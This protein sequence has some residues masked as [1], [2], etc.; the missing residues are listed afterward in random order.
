MFSNRTRQ[1]L[2]I[3]VVAD[4]SQPQAL[5]MD[6]GESRPV[7]YRNKLSVRY[8]QSVVGQSVS[9]QPKSAYF[10]TRGPQG[11]EPLRMEQL[12]FGKNTP[13]KSPAARVLPGQSADKTTIAVKLYVDDDEPTHR[14]IWEAK[15]RNRIAAAS[16]ILM[17]HCGVELQVVGVDTWDSDDNQHDFDRSLREFEREADPSPA[18]L[19]I[20]FSSQYQVQTGRHHAGGTRGAL[21]PYI[22][23]KERS[24]KTLE[25]Q[26]L[27]LLLHE[28]GHYLGASHSPEPQSIM[29]P[30][31]TSSIQRRAEAKIQFDPVNTLLMAML[32]DEIR[33]RRVKRL[34][35]VSNPT[36]IR[37][38]EIYSVLAKAMPGD[39][40][41]SQ[42]LSLLGPVAK[43]QEES[44]AGPQ[45]PRKKF[46]VSQTDQ[47]LAAAVRKMNSRLV[48]AVRNRRPEDPL[49][50]PTKWYQKDQ[51]TEFYVRQA[52]LMALQVNPQEPERAF[53][54]T[55]GIFMDDTG[56]LK[57]FPPSV[58]FVVL[59]ESVAQRNLRLKILDKP[60]IM[61]RQ[62]LA[63][64]FFVTAHLAAVHGPETAVNLGLAK[65]V[66]DSK[67]SS[68]FSHVDLLADLAGAEFARHV[69]DGEV[70]LE[71][72]SESFRVSDYMPSIGG[73]KEGQT[74]EEVQAEYGADGAGLRTKLQELRR[75]VLQLPVY[76]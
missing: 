52:A 44:Q 43:P 21:H 15:L 5:T 70:S 63:L 72:L 35:H 58:P 30:L 76:E 17:R 7:F 59:A 23:L 31:L 20:G 26:R 34:Y 60:T 50:D 65:E 22:M 57:M 46:E 1:P 32:S 74:F 56:A 12:G 45:E 9:V 6:I 33:Q 28:L 10:F 25:R 13:A 39:P 68:G 42:Y 40:A 2:T 4:V 69:L 18:Q 54:A 71:Q 37:M 14:R 16:E 27:E 3:S 75:R 36:K 62:D 55:L 53:L 19:A 41:A 67:G 61:D 24:P 47:Q 38:H 29:R 51:L 64:H 49:A 66:F 73:L 8:Q 11:N 48:R